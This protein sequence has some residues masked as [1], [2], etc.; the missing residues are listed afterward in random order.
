MAP[1]TDVLLSIILLNCLH[2]TMPKRHSTVAAVRG[3]ASFNKIICIHKYP[4]RIITLTWRRGL[5]VPVILGAVLLGAT[6]PGGVSLRQIGPQVR[7][8][9][10]SDSYNS[11]GCFFFQRCV[12][13]NGSGETGA[14]PCSQTWEGSSLVSIWWPGWAQPKKM[15]WGYLPVD[16]PPENKLVTI[17]VG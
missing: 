15:T 10:T 2:A 16:P 5:C 6:A 8:Q 12:T 7:G 1:V 9:T 17:F 3:G 13:S 14:P 4:P 11:D